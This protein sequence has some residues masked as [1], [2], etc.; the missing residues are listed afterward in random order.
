MATPTPP[1]ESKRSTRAAHIGS[2]VM[3]VLV[4]ALYILVLTRGHVPTHLP[5]LT[6]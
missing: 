2:L 1:S 6:H 4:V 3:T 5:F